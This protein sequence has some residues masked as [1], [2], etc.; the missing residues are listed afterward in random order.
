MTVFVF[1]FC[2][3]ILFLATLDIPQSSRASTA[4][5]LDAYK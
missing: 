3:F 4:A 5:T 1:R 2:V